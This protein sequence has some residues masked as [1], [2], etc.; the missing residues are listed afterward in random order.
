MSILLPE[1]II[2]HILEFNADFHPNLLACHEEMLKDPPYY[3]K[4][5]CGGFKPCIGD[6]VTWGDFKKCNERI[7]MDYNPETMTH[8]Y[9][10]N[11][12]VNLYAIEISAE[13]TPKNGGYN[14]RNI[15]LYY[16]WKRRKNFNHI[17]YQRW[18]NSFGTLFLGT[19]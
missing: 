1:E 14:S 12:Y 10:W 4:K 5:V 18:V 7:R 13:I 17:W 9:L 2:R 15:Y 8:N 6:H 16:G 19:Y 11:E 3:W